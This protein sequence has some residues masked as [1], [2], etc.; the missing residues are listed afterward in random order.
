MGRA[1]TVRTVRRY[2]RLA[3]SASGLVA[4]ILPPRLRARRAG[5][6]AARQ[7]GRVLMLLS[8]VKRARGEASSGRAGERRS[9]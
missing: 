1:S 5:G 9:V 3:S 6:R 8:P 4:L 2:R 7:A